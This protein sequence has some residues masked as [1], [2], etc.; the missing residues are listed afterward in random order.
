MI[1][2]YRAIRG[3]GVIV[4]LYA[5]DEDRHSPTSF[6]VAPAGRHGNASPLLVEV[7]LRTVPVRGWMS[8]CMCRRPLPSDW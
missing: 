6:G 3:T 2:W 8:Y 4:R 5:I 1:D 7:F